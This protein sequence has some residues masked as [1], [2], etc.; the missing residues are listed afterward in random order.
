MMR[1]RI[2]A[3]VVEVYEVCTNQH[4]RAPGEVIINNNTNINLWLRRA[5]YPYTQTQHTRIRLNDL[6]P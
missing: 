2:E 3:V 1:L 6:L 4:H 5:A